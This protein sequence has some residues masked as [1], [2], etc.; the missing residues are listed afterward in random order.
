MDLKISYNWINEYLKST[1]SLKEFSTE[2]S[3]KC[4]SVERIHPFAAKFS[5]VIT[6]KI[7]AI[8]S[9][10]NADKLRLPTV[11]T[12]KEKLQIVC[13]A[14]NIEV[15]Q[16]VPLALAGAVLG[17]GEAAFEIK[18]TNI[19]GVDSNGMLCSPKELGLGD[20]HS[21]ILILPDNTPLGKK[22]EDSADFKDNVLD[23][24]VT[25]NRTD[26][27]SVV[28]LAREG[29]AALDLKFNP[30]K[31]KP[32]LKITKN[33]PFKVEIK[34]PKM[35]PRY[36]AVVMTDVVVGPS[37]LWLQICLWQSGLRPIN[38]LVDITNYILL[39]YGRPMHVFDYDKLNDKKIIV[40]KA[41]AGEK[42]LA[43]DGKTYE[44]NANHLVIADGKIPAAVGGIMGG[45]DSAATKQTKTIV[46]ESAVF[47]PVLIRKTAR[48]LN[49]YSDSSSLFEKGLHPQSTTEGIL[50]AIELTQKIAGG[51]V[52]SKIIDVGLNKFQPKKIKFDLS[53]IKRY[54]A[55]DIPVVKVKKIL[56][57][58]GFAVAGNKTLT[59]TV[60]WF[61]AND[62]VFDYDLVEE[63]ARI[64][65]YHNLPTT[66]PV[67]EIPLQNRDSVFY[68]ENL[69]K[70]FL[71]GLGFTEV[72]NY[73]MVSEKFLA[74]AK[75]T[76]EKLIKI[77]NPLSE[78]M[79]VM[80]STLIAG[81]L[82]NVAENINNFSEIKI[83]ELSN[84]YSVKKE[85]ELPHEIVKLTGAV[86]GDGQAAFY[87]VKGI[88]EVFL[89]KFGQK[90]FDLKITDAACPL[91]QSQS[92]LDIYINQ[93]YF[94]QFGLIS[95]ELL[96]NYGLNKPVAIFDLD[97]SKLAGIGATIKTFQPIP[98]F[99]E[100]VRDLAIIIDKDISW[101]SVKE[102]IDKANPLLNHIDYLNTFIDP[103][104]GADKKS[105]ALRLVFR[106]AD[107][108][109]KSEEVESA[110][111][112][113]MA[114]LAEKLGA[115]LR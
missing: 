108:T 53:Q 9:H 56:S 74:Q 63:I 95:Q 79:A 28:G 73:S 16:I 69:A 61:R 103:A 90:K 31:P 105:L 115:K 39:E 104:L 64:Y 81:V 13:G 91:W 94:G 76:G 42:I 15:G 89:N 54:L 84:I 114:N 66:L 32:N 67:G 35:C 80:R 18:K 102:A 50:R 25:S 21:G 17:E 44:L 22:L 4:Q 23:I 97:F 109:L 55:V 110:T 72:Y 40:R 33:I 77:F 27:M 92:A 51:Q 70:N 107:R 83:F 82:D 38:N 45:Q 106:A 112:N 96:N 85:N 11:D 111:K 62:V 99:P 43:L 48:D 87:D 101:Q 41:K 8:D 36:S 5:G 2:M 46:F 98:E 7:I 26:A 6:A 60:P 100:S 3:L 29:A 20:D 37:P 68:W 86:V 49:L 34:E 24:E 65:G 75:F 93:E 59:V 19:R 10:P 52:A 71:A 58:L 14:P 47:D 78:D 113:V 12:G 30:I 57:A 88:M 1:K